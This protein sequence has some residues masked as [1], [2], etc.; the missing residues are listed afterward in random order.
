MV[1]MLTMSVG[2][3]VAGGLLGAFGGG[4]V[5]PGDPETL[6]AFRWSFVCVGL[7]TLTSAA[8]FAQLEPTHVI[9]QATVQKAESA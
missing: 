6:I 2:V 5:D 8:I 4:T 1:M 3:A 9:P 7:V